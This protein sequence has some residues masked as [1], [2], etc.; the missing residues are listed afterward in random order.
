MKRYLLLISTIALSMFASEARGQNE[1]SDLTPISKI[2]ES[3]FDN[4][5]LHP[6]EFRSALEDVIPTSN[7]AERMVQESLELYMHLQDRSSFL[8]NSVDVGEFA[9]IEIQDGLF[10]VRIMTNE[11]WEAIRETTSDDLPFDLR[12]KQVYTVTEVSKD[13]LMLQRQGTKISVPANRVLFIQRGTEAL[14]K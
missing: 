7:D 3:L 10:L 5:I 4:T 9:S 1:T 13:Y 14:V 12:A 8:G 2:G 11:Q 6:G